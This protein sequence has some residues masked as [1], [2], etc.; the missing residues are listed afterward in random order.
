MMKSLPRLQELEIIR[1][2]ISHVAQ[3]GWPIY[4]MD[5]KSTFLN[6]MLEEIYL[7]Q[8][9]S[10]MKVR[11]K[12][13]VLKLKKALYGL[14]QA[15]RAWNTRIDKYFK[16]NGFIQC[17]Y[18]HA[19][20]VKKKEGKLLVVGIYI[21]DLIFMGDNLGM[22]EKF[23]EEMKREFEMTDL[24]LMKYFFGLEVRQGPSGIFVS[25]KTYS[26][27]ILKKNKMADGNPVSTPMEPG[28]KLSRYDS[29]DRVDSTRYRSLVG[30]M[31]YLTCTRPDISYSVGVVSRFMEE[32]VYTHW[33]A[34]QRNL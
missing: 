22:V 24:G 27:D 18:E 31:H 5:V 9:P 29:G 30:S 34:L 1:L 33:K 16:K 19:L 11:K 32:P 25:Q 13:K 26:K 21:D 14:K 7:E 17:P 4:Q 2:L 15:P 20:Y 8:P 12:Y 10:Y 3:F 28:A 6:E 23:K